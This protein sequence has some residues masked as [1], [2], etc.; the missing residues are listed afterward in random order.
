LG[1]RQPAEHVDPTLLGEHY[2]WLPS[3]ALGVVAGNPQ[4]TRAAIAAIDPVR[5]AELADRIHGLSRTLTGEAGILDT[6]VLLE[7]R[8]LRPPAEHLPR[9]AAAS[10]VA[11]D[12]LLE[13]D[14]RG[15]RR[16]LSEPE[17]CPQAGEPAADDAD[18]GIQVSGQ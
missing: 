2:R 9:V 14:D 8:Q 13:E 15:V 7:A 18:V 1:R 16:Q 4:P 3:L 5:F 6:E 11:A 12:L 17:R 10:S